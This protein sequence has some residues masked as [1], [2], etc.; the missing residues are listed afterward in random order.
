ME[1]AAQQPTLLLP[2][3][4]QPTAGA[5]EVGVDEGEVERA[6]DQPGDLPHQLQGPQVQPLA[7]RRT[8][9]EG[10][11]LT[12]AAAERDGDQLLTGLA[13]GH[14][15][16]AV[17]GVDDDGGETEAVA[18]RAGQPFEDGAI[19]AGGADVGAESLEQLARVGGGP[20]HE[21]LHPALEP[22]PHGHDADRQQCDGE[23]AGG[24]AADRQ[25]AGRRA[26]RAR[27]TP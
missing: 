11:D 3:V 27:R 1:L 22:G 20:E 2:H 15:Q 9:P 17:V 19:V 6:G 5:L 14:P 16:R 23:Q 12:A 10:A 25:H 26:R 24:V 13:D 8:E 18:E 4:E 21:P 7:R